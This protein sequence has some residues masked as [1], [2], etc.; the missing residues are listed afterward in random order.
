MV[1]TTEGILG[2]NPETKGIVIDPSIPSEWKEYTMK[3][4]F[5]GKKL[6][7]TFNNPDHV[8]SGVKEIV[9][10]G[11]KLPSNH[12]PADKLKDVNDIVVTLGK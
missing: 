2:L 5:R 10:N 12:I 9:L 7:M 4:T 6:N 11:E 3:K 1:G 8:E